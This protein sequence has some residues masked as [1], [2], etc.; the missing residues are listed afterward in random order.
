MSSQKQKSCIF[1]LF[2]DCSFVFLSSETGRLEQ[3]EFPSPKWNKA[4]AKSFP[5]EGKPL[6]W[7]SLVH[8]TRFL[9]PFCQRREGT[10]LASQEDLMR[11]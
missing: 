9:F 4:L 5:V 7:G 1:C 10:V 3:E 8:F 6:L 11:S 2:V